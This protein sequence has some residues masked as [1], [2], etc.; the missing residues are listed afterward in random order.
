M[1]AS[2][3]VCHPSDQELNLV[4]QVSQRITYFLVGLLSKLVGK[5]HRFKWDVAVSLIHRNQLHGNTSH[6]HL[7]SVGRL[8]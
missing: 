2:L 3:F 8:W 7:L 5:I 1:Y 6:P 4:W